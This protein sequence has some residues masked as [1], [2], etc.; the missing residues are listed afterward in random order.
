MILNPNSENLNKKKFAFLTG[1]IVSVLAIL[2]FTVGNSAF[3]QPVF[4]D[5]LDLGLTSFYP[6][7]AS[8]QKKVDI[9]EQ[10]NYNISVPLN[11]EDI[12][13]KLGD[14]SFQSADLDF[15]TT[16]PT[17]PGTNTRIS[18]TGPITTTN[19]VA[20]TS[21]L[22]AVVA[23]KP[24][25]NTCP[26]EVQETQIAFFNQK[27]D[28]NT[29]AQALS[30]EGYLVYV[31]ANAAVQNE[32]KDK[33]I[34]L[35]CKPNAQGVIINGKT[36]KVTV[37]FTDIFNLLPQNLQQPAK[38]LPFVYSPKSDSIYLVNA[39]KEYDPSNPTK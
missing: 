3:A 19:G 12:K 31:T 1:M 25:L 11:V 4:T 15:S 29:K 21:K 36:Q 13:D 35:N 38:N 16:Q 39:R 20:E 24:K 23:G 14:G 28:A 17:V 9:L 37:D 32:A 33:I 27:D 22:Y 2:V 10:L 30:D 34:E 8:Q 26:V 7:A 6:D 5:K 18:F